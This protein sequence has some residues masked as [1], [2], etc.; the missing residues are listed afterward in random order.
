MQ[1]ILLLYR[2]AMQT[3]LDSSFFY[4]RKVVGA[5]IVVGRSTAELCFSR[6]VLYHVWRAVT[7]KGCVLL[8]LSRGGGKGFHVF[9][10]SNVATRPLV[11]VGDRF[12]YLAKHFAEYTFG[13]HFDVVSDS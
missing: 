7:G 8:L 13:T 3:E 10:R 2:T 11:A 4:R 1:Y 12:K 9:K 5:G 6:Y